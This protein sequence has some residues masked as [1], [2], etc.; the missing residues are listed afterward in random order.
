[1]FPNDF[2]LEAFLRALTGCADLT[3]PGRPAAPVSAIGLVDA[4]EQIA[5][6]ALATAR[7]RGMLNEAAMEKMEAVDFGDK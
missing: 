4:A 3:R 7:E 6:E 5:D 2:W 1:M